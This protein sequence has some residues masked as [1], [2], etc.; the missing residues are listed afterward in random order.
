MTLDTGHARVSG[1]DSAEIASFVGEHADR[2]SHFH[3][4]DTRGPSDEHLP[5][6]AGTI[7]FEVIFD[8][9]PDDWEGTM[10]L[11]VFTL[12]FDYIGA[13]KERLDALL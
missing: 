6:G 9:L 12:D 10:S 2:I 5:F 8:A 11:E 1:L 4:N 7:D 13:S 3:L